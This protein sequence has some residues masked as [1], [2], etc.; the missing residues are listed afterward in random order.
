MIY[1]WVVGWVA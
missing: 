1:N